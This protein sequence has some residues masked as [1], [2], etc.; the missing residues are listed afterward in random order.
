MLKKTMFTLLIGALLIAACAPKAVEPQQTSEAIPVIKD[1]PPQITPERD[2]EDQTDRMPCSAAY[3]YTTSPETD[4]Y[5][6]VIDQL[7]PLSDEDWVR[8]NPDAPITII[9]YADFQ[10]PACVQF[11]HLTDFLRQNFPNAVKL[12]FRH[13]PLPSIH[14]KAFIAGLAAEAA[15]AQG[16]FWEMHDLLYLYQGYWNQM[17]EDEFVDWVQEVAEG[18]ELDVD[19]FTK[20]LLNPEKRAW[21]E[22]LTEERFAIGMNYTPTVVVNDRIYRD[23]KPNLFGLLG[24]Y[25][26]GGTLECPAWVIDPEASYMARLNTSAGEID[27][28]LFADV[29]PIAV[30]SFVFLAQS[31]WYDD[32]YFHRVLPGFVAQAGDPSGLGII[33]PGY[34][35]VNET[36]DDL[37]FDRNGLFAMA[38]A[39]PDTNGSQFFITLAPTPSLD[40]GFTIFGQ[41]TE[42]SMPILDLIALRDPQTAVGFEDATIINGIEII[43]K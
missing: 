38:N 5:Q 34:T 7:P 32:V 39:G 13:L 43:K 19:Q 22:Q 28:E 11:S 25:E 14:D 12:A 3:D 27:I 42:D 41:V 18:W 29:A 17:T 21:I 4:Y 26:F 9:E 2:S 36:K 33:G 10:C 31:G 40:G 16:K 35:F 8:G 23:N 20:D 37:S 30:N 15:G 6:A 1:P 24:A